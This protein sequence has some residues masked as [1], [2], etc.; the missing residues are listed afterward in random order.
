M[1]EA[2]CQRRP[3]RRPVV[4]LDRDGTLNVEVGYI[5]DVNDLV[6][7]PEAAQAVTALNKAGLAAVLVTNQSGP[8]RGFYPESHVRALNQRL[9]SLLAEQGA[10]LDALYYCPHHAQGSVPEYA[11]K[12]TC[13][14]PATGL[15]ERAFA[16][17]ED[18]DRS[19]AYMVGDQSTDIE[20]ARNAG[21]N[22]VMVNTGFG[23]AVM[24]GEFQ[25]KV[26]P[27]YVAANILDAVRWIIADIGRAGRDA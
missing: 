10:R 1:S 16:E 15:I 4:F 27:D 22:A 24:S 20:L 26:D 18:L 3:Y 6:L 2:S 7:L 19:R 25:W 11:I 13:R 14:K 12:C 9:A 17:L 5:Y 8:A 21:I 23:R